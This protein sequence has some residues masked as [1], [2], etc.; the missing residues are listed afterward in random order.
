MAGVAL[1]SDEQERFLEALRTDAGFRSAVR[2]EVL[3]EELL[4][5]PGRV[6][7]L[8]ARLTER[9]DRVAE[10]LDRVAELVGRQQDDLGSLKGQIL[11]AK[12]RDRAAGYLSAVVRKAAVVPD[13][14]LVALL[15]DEADDVLLADL[16]ARGRLAADGQPTMAVV[17][18][19]WRVHS[20]DLDRA[21]ARAQLLLRATGQ[22]VLPIAVSQEDPGDAVA[23]KA[24][25]L[26]IALLQVAAQQALVVGQPLAAA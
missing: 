14:E 4:E 3:T 19:S 12:V 21:L 2:R 16:V 7:E 10:R 11:E 5:L 24:A 23:S 6:A 18:V 25:A 20:D 13:S 15:P 26:G 22:R 9:L 1:T 17:E 8:D